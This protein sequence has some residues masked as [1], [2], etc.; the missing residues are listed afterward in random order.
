MFAVSVDKH[1]RLPFF[2]G[3]FALAAVAAVAG[4]ILTGPLGM[5][6]WQSLLFCGIAMMIGTGTNTLG[7]YLYTPE[8][9]PTRMRAWATATGSSTNRLGSFTAP[10]VVGWILSRFD[11]IALVFGLFALVGIVASAVVW[12]FGEETKRRTLEELSP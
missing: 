10:W 1:G 7:V 8:L 12:F 6:G 11:S 3:G 4:A 9:Y 5:H 2:A